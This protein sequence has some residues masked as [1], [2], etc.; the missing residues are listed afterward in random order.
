VRRH[1]HDLIAAAAANRVPDLRVFGS[2]ARRPAG[3]RLF[4]PGPLGTRQEAASAPARRA[5]A[6]AVVSPERAT[7]PA[8]E[9]RIQ[10]ASQE[11]PS[12]VDALLRD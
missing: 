3:L 7:H 1:R 10:Q 2:V 5:C 4:W 12:C 9:P 8:G 6:P 11:S